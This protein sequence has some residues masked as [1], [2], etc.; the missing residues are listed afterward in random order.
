[1]EIKAMPTFLSMREGT[2]VDKLV[3]ANPEEIKR[4]VDGF[5]QSV[6]A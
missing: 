4:R 2:V 3:G 1:M 6:R 5:V